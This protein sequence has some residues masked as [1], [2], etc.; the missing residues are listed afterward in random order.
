VETTRTDVASENRRALGPAVLVMCLAL[1][2]SA[3]DATAPQ[4]FF[5]HVGSGVV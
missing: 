4:S 2:V 5:I 1:T 3:T